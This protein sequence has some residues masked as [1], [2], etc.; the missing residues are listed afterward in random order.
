MYLGRLA[1]VARL[2]F[3]PREGVVWAMMHHSDCMRTV[4]RGGGP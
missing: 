1:P 2:R 3:G 4:R